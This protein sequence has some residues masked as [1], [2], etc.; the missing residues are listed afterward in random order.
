MASSL[1]M[2]EG[3]SVLH[4]E[5]VLDGTTASTSPNVVI[6]GKLFSTANIQ[7]ANLT[8]KLNVVQT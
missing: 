2:N 6:D 5:V 4:Q 3:I 1:Y 8:N 7:G